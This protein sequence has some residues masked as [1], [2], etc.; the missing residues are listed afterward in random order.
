V[1]EKTEKS[2]KKIPKAKPEVAVE[3]L[4]P[5]SSNFGAIHVAS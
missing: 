2:N 3:E 4:D 1:I 5:R